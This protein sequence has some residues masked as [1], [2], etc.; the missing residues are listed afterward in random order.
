MLNVR[1]STTEREKAY[2]ISPRKRKCLT[3]REYVKK[4]ETKEEREREK[5][6][7]VIMAYVD[8]VANAVSMGSMRPL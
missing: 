3:L 6:Y 8:A 2:H 1:I 5:R 4:R 7:R